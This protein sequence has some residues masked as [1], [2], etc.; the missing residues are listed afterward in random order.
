MNKK[1]LIWLSLLLLFLFIVFLPTISQKQRL[2]ER[3]KQLKKDIVDLK[4]EN[5]NL[6]EEKILLEDNPEYLEKVA[7]EK[8]GLIK[9]GEVIYK[10]A[11]SDNKE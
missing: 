6:R 4:E 9:E 2:V 3:N 5:D 7:R 10:L 8:M 1:K 11:P